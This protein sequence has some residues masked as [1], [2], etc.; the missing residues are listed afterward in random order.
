[1]YLFCVYHAAVVEV[2]GLAWDQSFLPLRGS[3]GL[4]PGLVTNAFTS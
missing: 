3:Q 2:S 4:N 1:M